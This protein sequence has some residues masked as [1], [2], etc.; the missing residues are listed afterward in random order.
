MTS[1]RGYLS[2][3]SEVQMTCILSSWRQPPHHLLPHL[4]PDWFHLSGAGLPRLSWK[5]G[6]LT[7]VYLYFKVNQ[8]SQLLL[9]LFLSWWCKSCFKMP[10]LMPSA[11]ILPQTHHIFIGNW[12][13]GCRFLYIRSLTPVHRVLMAVQLFLITVHTNYNV[14]CQTTSLTKSFKASTVYV[15]HQ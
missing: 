15:H 11:E 1:R 2:V 4:H 5:R 13:K 6:R 3:W 14:V 8:L 10:F 12:V 9:P 7:G